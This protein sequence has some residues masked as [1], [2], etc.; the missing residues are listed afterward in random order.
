MGTI[1]SP[2][3]WAGFIFVFTF[4]VFSFGV[5]GKGNSLTGGEVPPENQNTKTNK[6]TSLGGAP[7]S[8]Q[9]SSDSEEELEDIDAVVERVKSI[10]SKSFAKIPYEAFRGEQVLR[11][12]DELAKDCLFVPAVQVSGLQQEKIQLDPVGYSVDQRDQ[13]NSYH[14][15]TKKAVKV[16]LRA[17]DLICKSSSLYVV[18]DRSQSM[19][20]HDEHLMGMMKKIISSADPS[21]GRIVVVGSDPTR[22]AFYDSQEGAISWP[23]FEEKLKHVGAN[24]EQGF[25]SALGA[26]QKYSPSSASECLHV[27]FFADEEE[28]SAGGISVEKFLKKASGACP[29]CRLLQVHAVFPLKCSAY[30]QAAMGSGGAVV[31]STHSRQFESL[32]RLVNPRY[33]VPFRLPTQAGPVL[34]VYKSS[35]PMRGFTGEGG[36]WNYEPHSNQLETTQSNVLGN[37]DELNILYQEPEKALLNKCEKSADPAKNPE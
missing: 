16:S 30:E 20:I 32:G 24:E 17:S 22:K 1:K 6:E 8:S 34:S 2:P 18:V 27:V 25:L 9:T 36:D 13:K 14:C 23:N 19:M 28:Q 35:K 21:K 37:Y 7:T 4:E 11:G 12:E 33:A 10:P 3:L 29:S 31:L 5:E 15:R 26:L